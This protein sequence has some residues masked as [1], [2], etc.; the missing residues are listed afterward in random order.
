MDRIILGWI[1]I[2]CQK[3]KKKDELWI[4]GL[5]VVRKRNAIRERERKLLGHAG[6]GEESRSELAV[7]RLSTNQDT[8][9]GAET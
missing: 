8:R 7:I 4:R 2:G 3:K 5:D 1:D 9:N 6:T